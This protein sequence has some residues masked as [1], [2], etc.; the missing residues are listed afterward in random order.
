MSRVKVPQKSR[1]EQGLGSG[2]SNGVERWSQVERAVDMG[3]K[4][5]DHVGGAP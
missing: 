4:H 2:A 1:S 3:E 5:A